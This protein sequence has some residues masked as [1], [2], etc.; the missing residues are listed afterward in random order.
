MKPFS[1]PWGND[2]TLTGGTGDDEV[3]FEWY[4]QHTL[5]GGA[6]LNTLVA[7]QGN[8]LYIFDGTLGSDIITNGLASGTAAVNK[9]QFL[10]SVTDEKLWLTHFRQTIWISARSARRT[11]SICKTGSWVAS[12]NSCLSK[13]RT[14]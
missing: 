14:A 9:M 5:S 1:K 10:N 4:L 8:N 3:G 2:D 11:R 13:M 12:I 6:G 7:S